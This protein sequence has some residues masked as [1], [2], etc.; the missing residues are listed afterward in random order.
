MKRYG[1][2]IKLKPGKYEAYKRYH[3]A[4]WP[5]VASKIAECNIRNYSIYHKDGYLFAYFEYVG[6][7]F[8]GDMAAMA[9]D[10][11]T[12][13]WWA[14]VKPFQEPLSTRSSGEWWSD[15]EELFHQD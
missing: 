9:A 13:E 7:D 5:E 12:Q 2:V 10:P 6:K 8:D 3:A 1:Q 15:M 4:V 11:K 14:V